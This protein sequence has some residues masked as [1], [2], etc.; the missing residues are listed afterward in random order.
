MPKY[1]FYRFLGCV[2][3]FALPTSAEAWIH[4]SAFFEC[5]NLL[6]LILFKY[7]F[8]SCFQGALSPNSRQIS[9]H[10][11]FRHMSISFCISSSKT[12]KSDRQTATYK[13]TTKPSFRQNV[14]DGAPFERE[15]NRWKYLA[16]LFTTVLQSFVVSFLVSKVF[17]LENVVQK[18]T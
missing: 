16:V 5:W 4:I 13:K 18:E 8:P 2:S 14:G 11:C 3:P 10:N 9:K 15:P 17:F 6:T 1:W 7:C 12:P